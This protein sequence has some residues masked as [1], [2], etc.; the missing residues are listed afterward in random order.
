MDTSWFQN[1]YLFKSKF[2]DNFLLL[3]GSQLISYNPLTEE[4]EVLVNII[5]EG[6]TGVDHIYEDR[7]G[8][9]WI[10]T[11]FGF[12]IYEPH[13]QLFETLLKKDHDPEYT[14]SVRIIHP[15]DSQRLFISAQKENFFYD[16]TD[17]QLESID[18]RYYDIWG[19]EKILNGSHWAVKSGKGLLQLD[20][21]NNRFQVTRM[22]TL[23]QLKAL[24]HHKNVLWLSHFKA[25]F[26]Y[27]IVSQSV[28]QIPNWTF[29]HFFDMHF[30]E[31]GSKWLGTDR[32]LV[33]MDADNNISKV[34][35]ETSSPALSNQTIRN[36]H[37]DSD[38]LIWLSTVGGGIN[39]LDQE[40]DSIE[41]ITMEH[42]LSNDNIY[43]II[44]DRGRYWIPTDNGLN[45]MESSS[46][47]IRRF[48]TLDGLSHHEFNY[49]GYKVYQDKLYLGTLNGITIVDL[50]TD[51][52]FSTDLPIYFSSIR[53]YDRKSNQSINHLPER[54]LQQGISLK[55]TSFNLE[56]DF[57][58]ASYHNS[59]DNKYFYRI[60]GFEPEWR[61]LGT[62]RQLK[63]SS[64]PP[65]QYQLQIKAMN[66]A[67][68]QNNF[69]RSLSIHVAKPFTQTIAFFSLVFFGFGLL[70]YAIYRVRLQQINKLIAVRQRI[71]INLHD[72]VG[73]TMSRIAMESDLLRAQ[74]YDASQSEQKL[75]MI[76]QQSREAT[77]TMSDIIWSFDASQ[78]QA[79]NL[80]D[81]MRQHLYNMLGPL[82][83]AY[84]FQISGLDGALKMKPEVRQNIYLIFKEAI[85]NIT[86]HSNASEVSISL[87]KLK[88]NL[89]H[90]IKDNGDPNYKST[91]E[92]SGM[93]LRNMQMR[94]EKINGTI[95]I[96]RNPHFTIRVNIPL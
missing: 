66:A 62:Q 72:E 82:D 23:N 42:G 54:Y 40:N 41:Y 14:R 22:E 94:A 17:D 77:S 76:A 30:N 74:V 3:N 44:P 56:F 5:D 85:H 49:P 68:I 84:D 37:I 78:D 27:D 55:P 80:I 9:M 87:N 88:G 33:L 73:S 59:Q 45:L 95:H 38:G 7:S 63:I 58:L 26:Q 20:F 70:F 31:D 83:I 21:E 36:I 46:R 53:T 10:S 18:T 75:D 61:Y 25:L 8:S 65:G 96:E 32:G 24:R 86:K 28:S 79:K 19:V 57:S 43:A 60:E 1:L 35:S 39:I 2:N 47:T 93:G 13:P 15:I 6:L 89:Y 51:Y 91:S 16:I 81:R 52:S 64:L 67:G 11:D 48:S 4:Y 34:Y 50:N 29:G 12:Y 90:E 71:A 69:I 92:S